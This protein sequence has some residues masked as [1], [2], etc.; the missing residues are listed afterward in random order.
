MGMI[1][2]QRMQILKYIQ[3]GDW[4]ELKREDHFK[5]VVLPTAT[6]PLYAQTD[7][8]TKQLGTTYFTPNSIRVVFDGDDNFSMG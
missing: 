3:K 1:P 8:G 5:E 2:I 6:R 7:S 4:I